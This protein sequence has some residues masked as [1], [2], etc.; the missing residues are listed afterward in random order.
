LSSLG[1]LENFL[2]N[3]NEAIKKLA[4]QSKE[5]AEHL[6]KRI[7]ELLDSFE[8]YKKIF[9]PNG[10]SAERIQSQSSTKPFERVKSEQEE[11]KEIRFNDEVYAIEDDI[12]D[13]LL[14]SPMF[15]TRD[16]MFIRILG[17][18]MTRKY[19]TQETLQGITGLSSGKISEEVNKLLEDG[20]INKAIISP[21]GKITYEA[22]SLI[23]LRFS[24]YI[25]NIMTKWVKELENMKLELE[26]NRFELENLKGYN[27][28]YKIYDYTL[29]AILKYAEYIKRIDNFVEL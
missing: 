16:P 3:K 22:N 18:F 28:I 8:K 9:P 12:I 6:S 4:E 27:Q 26:N 24:R 13:Q 15:S 14:A 7:E 20:L 17:Y 19:L 2:R 21:K 11:V 5:G 1:S 29:D 25:I 10:I 23:L